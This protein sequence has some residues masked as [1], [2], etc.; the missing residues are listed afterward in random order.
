MSEADICPVCLETPNWP[1]LMSTECKHVGCLEC[2]ESLRTHG[3]DLQCAGYCGVSGERLTLDAQ[4]KGKCP[5]CRACMTPAPSP[6]V[7]QVNSTETRKR[8]R[9]VCKF[10]TVSIS[11]CIFEYIEH[12]AVCPCKLPC[13]PHCKRGLFPALTNKQFHADPKL[14][15]VDA[16]RVHITSNQCDKLKCTGCGRVGRFNEVTA[17]ERQ[18]VRLQA[19]EIALSHLREDANRLPTIEQPGFMIALNNLRVAVQRFSDRTRYNDDDGDDAQSD[20]GNLSVNQ[21]QESD[22]SVDGDDGAS[23]MDDE[24][25]DNDDDDDHN[26]EPDTEANTIEHVLGAHLSIARVVRWRRSAVAQLREFARSFARHVE[27]VS[28]IRV[29]AP[30]QPA[31]A[32]IEQQ[33]LLENNQPIRRTG[34]H[35]RNLLLVDIIAAYLF[36]QGQPAAV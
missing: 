34:S 18:H 23:D 33:Q 7:V 24:T 31:S 20:D 3:W 35:W 22:R 17:C 5:V 29:D 32:A 26:S 4:F 12:L 9:F 15:F 2:V 30:E 36:G 28:A 14:T 21:E 27:R 10:C 1:A 19:V 6:V 13:C 11:T 8:R 16:L 25:K